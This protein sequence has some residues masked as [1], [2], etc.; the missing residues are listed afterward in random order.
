VT[1][2]ANGSFRLAHQ[3]GVSGITCLVCEKTSFNPHDV[4]NRYCANCNLW[5]DNPTVLPTHSCFDDALEYI[6]KR[7][8]ADPAGSRGLRLVHC[9]A[10]VRA[11][12]GRII[13]HAFVLEGDNWIDQ[14]MLGG[15]V[16]V[17]MARTREEIEQTLRLID[18]TYYS[19]QELAIENL[20][21]GTF[22]PWKP[23][24]LA[25]CRDKETT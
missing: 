22:G 13:S 16:R 9:L 8:K 21:T 24:Y 4:S 14:G 12:P 25:R 10:E 3:E 19:L 18:I 7:V 15:V 5:H 23:E 1:D 2:T 20:R 17:I 6:S 11:E